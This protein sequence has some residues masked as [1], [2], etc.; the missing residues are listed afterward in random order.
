MGRAVGEA[1][2]RQ[3]THM[4]QLPVAAQLLQQLLADS[5]RCYPCKQLH[6]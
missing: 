6:C 4:G 2:L 1:P 5:M 3:S